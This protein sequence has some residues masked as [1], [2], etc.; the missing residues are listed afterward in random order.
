MK[1]D[2]PVQAKASQRKLER[3]KARKKQ[4]KPHTT[5]TRQEQ[6]ATASNSQQQP[7]NTI[8]T[9]TIAAEVPHI[10]WLRYPTVILAI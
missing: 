9:T 1:S 6:P 2:K 3:R 7:A 4:G 8:T 10:K 5:E